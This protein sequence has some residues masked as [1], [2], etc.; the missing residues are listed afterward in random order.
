MYA[1]KISRRSPDPDLTEPHSTFRTSMF[2]YESDMSG[3]FEEKKGPSFTILGHGWHVKGNSRMNK[4]PAI[5]PL[6][7]FCSSIQQPGYSMIQQT[8]DRSLACSGHLSVQEIAAK[9]SVSE[10]ETEVWDIRRYWHAR[11]L[12]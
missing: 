6:E 8:E 9:K 4:P 1:H 7:G 2:G 3:T 5:P 11:E 10:L 12:G